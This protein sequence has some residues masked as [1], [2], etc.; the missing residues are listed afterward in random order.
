VE[1]SYLW[2]RSDAVLITQIVEK[3]YQQ[4]KNF[5]KLSFL[6][7]TT[8]STEKLSKMQNIANARGDPMSRFHNALYAGD[9][10]GRIEVLRD[11]GMCECLVLMT[12]PSSR[13]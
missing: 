11:V 6:Y 8:G 3:A 2:F 13:S 12:S 7:L 1:L 9:V 5:D 4:T 10:E